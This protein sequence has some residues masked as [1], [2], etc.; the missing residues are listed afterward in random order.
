MNELPIQQLIVE[1]VR[2][3]PGILGSQL[4]GI[5]KAK[6]PDFNGLRSFILSYCRNDVAFAG[7]RGTDT[8][9]VPTKQEPSPSGQAGAFSLPTLTA[10][11]TP[12]SEGPSTARS[13]MPSDGKGVPVRSM[14]NRPGNLANPLGGAA[15]LWQAFTNPSYDSRLALDKAAT[16]LKVLT[17]QAEPTNDLILVPKVTASEHRTIALN[18]LERLDLG[19]RE[20]FGKILEGQNPW[21]AWSWQTQHYASGKYYMA[22][23]DFRTQSLQAL[24]EERIKTLEV[25]APD[26]PP[27]SAQ[28]LES[29]RPRFR[30]SADGLRLKTF[31]PTSSRFSRARNDQNQA[32][33]G[34]LLRRL[35][36]A[37]ISEMSPDDLRRLWVPLGALSNALRGNEF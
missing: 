34:E 32:G 20:P 16:R 18:F 13:P 6:Y 14:S 22:W 24:F 23:L 25:P 11:Q 27:L 7:R 26:V 36:L 21:P 28:L 15:T 1:T 35:A 5:V 30:N 17:P 3:N 9:Y 37:A 2:R 31:P 19:D 33:D 12:S 8:I 29:K 10:N 4:G